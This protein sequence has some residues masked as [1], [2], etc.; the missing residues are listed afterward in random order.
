MWLFTDIFW[1]ISNLIISMYK[2]F[3]SYVVPLLFLCAI[4]NLYR[5]E[6]QG[7]VHAAPV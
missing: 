7:R 1:Y 4:V 6:K 5:G 2:A 3:F